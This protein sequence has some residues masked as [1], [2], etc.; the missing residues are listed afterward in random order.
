MK[1]DTILVAVSLLLIAPLLAGG[2]SLLIHSSRWLHLV[3]LTSMGLLVSA[4]VVIGRAVLAQGSLTVLRDLVYID[5]LSSLILFIIGTVGLACS[6]YMR[7]YMD[8]QVARGVIAPGRLNLFFFLFHMFLLAMVV[9]TVANSLGVQW[10][11][12]E[13]TTLATTFLIAFWRRRESLEAGWKYLILCSVGISLALFGVVLMYYSSLRVL[14]DVSSAL[15][16][17]QLQQVGAQLDPHILKLAFV[18]LFIGYGTKVGLVPMHSWLPDA[19]TEAPAPVAAMLAG[20]LETVAVYAILR[21]RGIVDQAVPPEFSGSLLALFGLVSFAVAAFFL[22]LQHNYKRLLAYSS[23]EHMGLAMIGLGVGGLIGTFGGLFHLINHAFAKSLAFFAAGNIHR[24]YKS[25]EIDQVQGLATVLPGSAL[26]LMIAGLA[27][28]AL[29]P[30]ALF[31]SEMQIITALGT[32]GLPGEWGHAGVGLPVVILLLCSL[33][34]FAGFLYRITGMIWGGAPLRMT[35]G[36]SW[37]AGHLSLILLSL[38][39][40]GLCWALPLPLQQ[41]LDS[42]AAMLVH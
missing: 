8:E 7:S 19:Y 33:V 36:E 35:V 40:L 20:V 10:V 28:A 37:S 15:N 18:F 26:A 6:L 1:A 34:A 22:L 42:A 27:L 25:V 17:T 13:A 30:F 41:L 16:I 23:I 31:A 14:G 11:A 29:P 5:A 21:S 2:L 24:R 39:L 38:L 32:S 3:N 12:I 9:A 4:E